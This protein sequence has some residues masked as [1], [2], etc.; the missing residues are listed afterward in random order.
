MHVNSATNFGVK[1]E[2]NPNRPSSLMISLIDVHTDL[3][4]DFFFF[5]NFQFRLQED[6]MDYFVFTCRLFHDQQIVPSSE[7]K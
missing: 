3:K 4:Y 6:E 7:L 1:P 2:K 5:F